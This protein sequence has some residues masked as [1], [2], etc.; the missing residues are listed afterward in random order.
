M[1]PK[2]E[3]L[4]PRS[5]TTSDSLY[6]LLRKAQRGD[7]NASDKLCREFL[8][9]LKSLAH[10]RLPGQAR[11]QMDTD[12]VVQEV[13]LKVIRRLDSFDPK[14]HDALR[15]YLYTSVVN[16]IKDEYK[17]RR[18]EVVN[19]EDVQ[20][21]AA[22]VATPLEEVIG[23]EMFERYEA[24]LERLKPQEREMLVAKIELNLPYDQIARLFAKGTPAAARIAVRR[25]LVRLAEEMSMKE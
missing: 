11:G 6:A 10:G 15:A 14:H 3:A 13:F 16:R 2:K 18:P 24:S 19:L 8:P 20:D 7:Q 25:A 23:H 1:D 21:L 22:R 5:E 12:D 17:R 9:D 4:M